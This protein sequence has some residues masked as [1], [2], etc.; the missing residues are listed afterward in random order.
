VWPPVHIISLWKVNASRSKQRHKL[1]VLSV[2]F[3]DCSCGLAFFILLCFLLD[4][5]LTSWDWLF[6]QILK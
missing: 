5:F 3:C 2:A 4:R 1:V 6:L